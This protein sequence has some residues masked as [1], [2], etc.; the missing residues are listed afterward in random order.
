MLWF[1]V[2]LSIYL[3][4][5]LGYIMGTVLHSILKD[6]FIS[7]IELPIHLCLDLFIFLFWPVFLMLNL[8]LGLFKKE[9]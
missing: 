2:F 6:R 9:K 8:S 7:W 1:K 4:L 5:G 3:M